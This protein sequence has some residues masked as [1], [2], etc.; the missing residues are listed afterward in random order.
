MTNEVTHYQRR[1]CARL[2]DATGREIG[3]N[4]ARDDA[5]VKWKLDDYFPSE[6]SQ[7]YHGELLEYLCGIS[8]P[9]IQRNGTTV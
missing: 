5:P 7:H 1:I 4:F 3:T 8:K 2:S 6:Q 9:P